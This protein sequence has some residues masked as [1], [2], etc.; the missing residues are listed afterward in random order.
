MSVQTYSLKQDGDR[1]L[2]ANFR[3]REFACKDGSDLILIC[4]ETARM[5]QAIRNYFGAPVTITSGYRTLAHNRRVGSKDT[6][7]HVKGMAADIVVRHQTP[8][9]VYRAIENGWVPGINPSKIGLGLYPGFVHIDS[10]G[11]RGR[12]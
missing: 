12:W 11:T 8:L 9:Q 2:S 1:V 6:S 3:V 10:R 5:V 4:D 7:F